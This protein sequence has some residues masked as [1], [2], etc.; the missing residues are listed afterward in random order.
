[1]HGGQE[2]AGPRIEKLDNREKG[3]RKKKGMSFAPKRRASL[4]QQQKVGGRA[5]Q[6]QRRRRR[7][8]STGGPGGKHQATHP[9]TRRGRRAP[10][11]T[12]PRSGSQAGNDNSQDADGSRRSRG[13]VSARVSEDSIVRQRLGGF[14]D[15]DSA[16][17]QLGVLR[18]VRESIAG[19]GGGGRGGQDSVTR[20]GE[21][22]DGADPR[23]RGRRHHICF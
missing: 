18:S 23:H 13:R 15:Y 1:M 16:R 2:K 8:P 14:Y 19:R 3:R 20:P 4:Q 9:Q 7:S 17:R 12:A 10:S 5:I 22:G 6:G 11:H 21:T